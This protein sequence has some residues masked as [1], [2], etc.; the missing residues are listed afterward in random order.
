L[1]QLTARTIHNCLLFALRSDHLNAN[2]S[3]RTQ[4]TAQIQTTI[5][6]ANGLTGMEKR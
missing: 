2:S 5:A 1:P 3:G 4:V 6:E